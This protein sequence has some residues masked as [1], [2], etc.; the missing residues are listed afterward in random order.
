MGELKIS[1][2]SSC[3]DRPLGE[4]CNSLSDSGIG[5]V[6]VYLVNDQDLGSMLDNSDVRLRVKNGI[7]YWLD[8]AWRGSPLPTSPVGEADSRVLNA[9]QTK[10]AIE[11][12]LKLPAGTGLDVGKVGRA[13]SLAV[14]APDDIR[15]WVSAQTEATNTVVTGFASNIPGIANPAT[16]PWDP[17]SPDG[18]YTFR[19]HTVS[20]QALSNLWS[21]AS[22]LGG[23]GTP[24][25]I[26]GGIGAEGWRRGQN[27]RMIHGDLHLSFFLCRLREVVVGREPDR[28]PTTWAPI[29]IELEPGDHYLFRDHQR[30]GWLLEQ[31]V[32][33]EPAF[34]PVSDRIGINL[35]I[36]HFI[37]LSERMY[38]GDPCKL[39]DD[40]AESSWLDRIYHCHISDHLPRSHTRDMP[41]GTWHKAEVYKPWIDLYLEAGRKS[42]GRGLWSGTVAVELEGATCLEEVLQ[43][44]A[45]ACDVV[46]KAGVTPV[47]K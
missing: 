33:I 22:S 42:E 43:A 44:H 11:A 5:Y 15:A 46:D 1:L 20:V 19:E 25:E 10:M 14:L 40:L 35:D 39:V 26:V 27:V 37:I 9:L 18:K 17:R 2:I 21:A 3:L 6:D 12:A 32:D 34:G 16:V 23:P 47:L 29:V 41:L 31:L 28:S 13:L 4:L 24:L 36:G 38:E 8:H 7:A 45:A 30:C